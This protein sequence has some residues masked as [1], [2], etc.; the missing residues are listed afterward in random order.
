VAEIAGRPAGDAR[1]LIEVDLVI[2]RLQDHVLGKAE[3][4]STQVSAALGLLKK[5]MPD[6][7]SSFAVLANAEK[8]HDE[9]LDELE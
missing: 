7:P 5:S 4:T 3:L 9:L 2:G 8:S 6:L 1:A